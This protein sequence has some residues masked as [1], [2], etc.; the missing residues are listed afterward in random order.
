VLFEI[1]RSA[2]RRLDGVH[3][4]AVAARAAQIKPEAWKKFVKS[5]GGNAA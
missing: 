1:H 5:V 4:A 2:D 3:D